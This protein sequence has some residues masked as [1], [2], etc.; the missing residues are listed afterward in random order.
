MSE[1]PL[2]DEIEKRLEKVRKE[3]VTEKKRNLSQR[4]TTIVITLILAGVMLFSI[5]RYF[6]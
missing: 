1:D 3:P 2:K 6:W 4:L 5:L